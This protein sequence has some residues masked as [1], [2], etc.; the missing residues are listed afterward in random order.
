MLVQI[1]PTYAS[2]AG[3]AAGNY[4]GY[5]S[6]FAAS[7]AAFGRPVVIGFGH[8]MNATWYSWGYHHVP[9]AT[10]VA[11]WRHIVTLFRDQGAGNVTWLWTI[12]ATLGS[13]GPISAWWP[14]ARY[15]TWVGVDGYYYRPRDSFA[16]VFAPTLRQVRAL[17]GKPVLLSET[18]VGPAA[19]QP[20]KIGNLF[21]GM[22]ESGALGLVWFDNTQHDGIYH[23]DWRL[24]GQ[25]AAMAAFRAGVAR[26]LRRAAPDQPRQF[27][28]GQPWLA[29]RV[30]RCS[31]TSGQPGRRNSQTGTEHARDRYFLDRDIPVA[32]TSSRS[33]TP[34]RCQHSWRG[35]RAACL[36]AQGR[37]QPVDI[38]DMKTGQE[39]L[40]DG[41]TA[42]VAAGPDGQ[43][44]RAGRSFTAW[45]PLVGA[46]RCCWSRRCCRCGWC[47]LTRRS[48]MRRRTCGPGTWSGRT[49][50]MARRC[51]RSRTYFSG[52]PVIYPPLG[53]LADSVG[54]LAGARVLSLVFMLG[55]TALLWG[56]AGRLFGRRAA[57]FAAALFAV[58]GPTLHLGAFATYDALSVLLVALAAWC[59]VRAGDRGE[60]TGWMVA[61][62]VAL[63]LANAAAYSSVLFDLVV[64]A[65]ALLTALPGR[66]AGSPPGGARPC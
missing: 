4:D 43:A 34:G 1:D 38:G 24:E 35:G 45:W 27:H 13:T 14:G 29:R 53:A 6:S 46:G 19:G 17:T 10:F 39:V 21:T 54:G 52:A 51:R 50:C 7:V 55:A 65:L 62:G 30:R 11:A 41:A 58:L 8:E 15:V 47:G 49:G 20:A 63:A 5:L 31:R 16:S 22:R 56:T 9:P 61:A 25:P 37:V 60:A 57:F 28:G 12:N 40:A 26:Q 44:G 2:V 23:Q 48:R 66:A 36:P 32:G 42:P 64:L 18:A 33:V 59:V 3:I